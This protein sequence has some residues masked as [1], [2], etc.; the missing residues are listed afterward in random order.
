M[1]GI[2]SNVPFP[3]A[4]RSLNIFRKRFW[5]PKI[6]SEAPGIIM[7]LSKFFGCSIDVCAGLQYFHRY[8]WYFYQEW[9]HEL[10][11]PNCL[12]VHQLVINATVKRHC[13]SLIFE[14]PGP[15]YTH[16]TF[17]QH[18]K[19]GLLRPLDWEGRWTFSFTSVY[20]PSICPLHWT[21]FAVYLL[22]LLQNYWTFIR[23]FFVVIPYVL[24]N[25]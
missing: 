10:M 22:V 16:S 5:W 2:V 24:Q 14:F 3:L 4:L 25:F 23:D 1:T 7:N 19:R 8:G 11:W 6:L 12:K 15:Q 18:M 21:S 20:C 17:T 9:G 13:R